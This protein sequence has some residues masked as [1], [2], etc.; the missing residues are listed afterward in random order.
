M[1]PMNWNSSSPASAD[2]GKRQRLTQIAARQSEAQIVVQVSAEREPG[3]VVTLKFRATGRLESAEPA[4]VVTEESV[5][6]RFAK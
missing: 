3:T 2:P 6:F 5:P 4:T 1:L